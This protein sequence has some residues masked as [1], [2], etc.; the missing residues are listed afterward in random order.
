MIGDGYK[1]SGGIL[2]GL[3]SKDLRGTNVL[4]KLKC[5]MP[6]EVEYIMD[7]KIFVV[8]FMVETRN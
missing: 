2:G 6:K 1:V 8:L 5:M 7:Y 3:K 4:E